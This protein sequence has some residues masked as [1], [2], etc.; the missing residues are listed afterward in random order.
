MKK[1]LIILFFG[2][3]SICF[4][5][6][7]HTKKIDDFSRDLIMLISNKNKC[8]LKKIGV[9]P[10]DEIT[11]EAINYILGGN[12]NDGF[13]EMFSKKNIVYRISEPLMDSN[14][15]IEYFYLTFY[16]PKIIKHDINGFISSDVIREHWGKNYVETLIIIIDSKIKFYMTPFFYETDT[17]W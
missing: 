12:G 1:N 9:F 2:H 16:N 3:L 10:K 15:N 5:Q 6:D 14:E 13:V 4:A 11:S 7:N 8:G 17:F